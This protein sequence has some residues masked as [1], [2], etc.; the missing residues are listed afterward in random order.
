VNREDDAI[1]T[2]ITT[3]T[4]TTTVAAATTTTISI[5]IIVVDAA[6]SR[7]STAI[8]MC[9]VSAA[10]AVSSREE[11]G[12]ILTIVIPLERTVISRKSIYVEVIRASRT[13]AHQIQK[14]LPVTSQ[15]II[16][17]REALIIFIL[18]INSV[19]DDHNAVYFFIYFK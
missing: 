2:P 4:T 15:L 7:F 8:R 18:R 1:I 19:L 10:V 9:A 5:I 3:T 12:L 11:G 13:S 17:L 6:S 16:E 14:W